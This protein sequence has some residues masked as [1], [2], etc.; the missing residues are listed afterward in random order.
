MEKALLDIIFASKKRMKVLLLLQDGPLSTETILMSLAT[1]RQSLLPQMKM[2][3]EHSL[4]IHYD[5]TYELTTIGNLIVGEM[6]PLLG[7]IRVFDGN[8]KHWGTRKL[9]FIPPDLLK[10][11]GEL[12]KCEIRNPPVEEAFDILKDFQESS[13]MSMFVFGVNSF[14]YPNFPALFM[15]LIEHC[16]KVNFIISREL[17]EKLLNNH[18]VQL[19]CLLRKDLLNLYV[20]PRKIDFMSFAYNDY[21]ILLSL[22]KDNG[23]FDHKHILCSSMHGN[24]WAKDFF[25][26]YLTNSIPITEI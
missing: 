4:V 14:F 11:I 18:D 9:D 15:E 7:T 12:G 10:R 8:T 23:E 2:L 3:E 5:D 25:E 13:K 21:Q 24:E 17:L 19:K 6:I 22:L 20:Y 1:T 16:V 26:Y